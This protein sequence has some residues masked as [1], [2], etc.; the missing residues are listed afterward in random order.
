LP[1]NPT[2]DDQT[3]GPDGAPRSIRGRSARRVAGLVVGL[4][5]ILGFIELVAHLPSSTGASSIAFRAAVGLGIGAVVVL[6]VRRALRA[7]TEPPPP[8][9]RTVDAR[10]SEVV[11]VCQICGTRLRLEL[12]AT[13]KAPRH[14]GEEMEPQL[15]HQ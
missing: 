9:P 7:L 5:V 10:T 1:D 2:Y 3:G 8:P 13:T 6:I 14:C 4:V 11:Y 15:A 12:A